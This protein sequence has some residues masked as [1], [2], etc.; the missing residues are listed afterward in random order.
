MLV[1]VVKAKYNKLDKIMNLEKVLQSVDAIVKFIDP[2]KLLHLNEVLRSNHEFKLEIEKSFNA[3]YLTEDQYQNIH[4]YFHEIGRSRY[5]IAESQNQNIYQDDYLEEL[6]KLKENMDKIENYSTIRIG[7]WIGK[8]IS[9]PLGDLFVNKKNWSELCEARENFKALDNRKYE[10]ISGTEKITNIDFWDINLKITKEIDFSSLDHR[11][12]TF[13]KN[14]IE[15]STNALFLKESILSLKEKIKSPK[16]IRAIELMAAEKEGSASYDLRK[17]IEKVLSKKKVSYIDG[18]KKKTSK[19]VNSFLAENKDLD[20]AKAL[21]KL[22]GFSTA[23]A[24]IVNEKYKTMKI[25][26]DV[27]IEIAAKELWAKMY[28]FFVRRMIFKISP[29]VTEKAKTKNAFVMTTENIGI[30]GYTIEG[31]FYFKFSDNSSFRVK[32]QAVYKISKYGRA[33]YQFPTH[34]QNIVIDGQELKFLP[35][36][37]MYMKFVN[38]KKK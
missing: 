14:L 24:I 21:E 6:K 18:Y 30:Q 20:F 33:F 34:F 26:S 37:E 7:K 16:E 23:W 10:C 28:E 27:S 1:Y 25:T 38:I 29:I 36:E 11:S 32:H 19:L 13:F 12:S 8:W 2:K 3:G 4:D 35:E 31:N 5:L 22:K 17:Q 15:Y 9:N